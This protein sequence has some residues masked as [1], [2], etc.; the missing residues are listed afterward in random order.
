MGDVV[1]YAR[2]DGLFEPKHPKAIQMVK[3]NAGKMFI[4][5]ITAEP[6]TGLQNRFLNGWVYT[7]QI[8]AKLN[9]AG[10]MNPVGGIWTRDI[11]HCMMQD[12]FLV[13]QE[14]LHN[15][16]HV[17]VYEST[18]DMSRK[19]FCKYID[20][21]IKPLVSSMWEIEIENPRDGI[22]MEIYKEMMK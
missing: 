7:K 14:F 16:R 8:C 11:I 12:M 22:F 21:Q 15:G 10:I 9:D 13:K 6:R 5:N 18:A 2:E 4:A 19:R 3:D 17:K 20:E 1:L